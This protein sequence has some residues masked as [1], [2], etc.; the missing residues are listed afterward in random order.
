MSWISWGIITLTNEFMALIYLTL[1]PTIIQIFISEP[2]VIQLGANDLKIIAISEI[3]MGIESV[4]DG[5]AGDT[6][7]LTR[8]SALLLIAHYP[9]AYYLALM[10]CNNVNGVWLAIALTG[11]ACGVLIVYWFHC[12]K[13]KEKEV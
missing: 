10:L 9:L 7:P 3:F 2:E 11:I 6:L 13:W 4:L 1:S 5:G 8:I 12:G